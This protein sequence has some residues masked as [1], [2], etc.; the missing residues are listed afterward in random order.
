MTIAN[1]SKSWNPTYVCSYI[2]YVRWWPLDYIA[3]II[4]NFLNPQ[5]SRLNV[6][7]GNLTH[8]L[9]LKIFMMKMVIFPL[10]GFVNLRTWRSYRVGMTQKSATFYQH[11]DGA[12]S[13]WLVILRATK[14]NGIGQRTKFR[15]A[16]ELLNHFLKHVLNKNDFPSLHL[17]IPMILMA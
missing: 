14:Q 1:C 15:W 16:W 9:N 3:S 4:V 11:I 7:L 8:D 6:A 13:N 17:F 2:G 10:R 12:A 5:L